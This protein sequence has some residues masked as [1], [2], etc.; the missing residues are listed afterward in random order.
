MNLAPDLTRVL[1][2][3]P[4]PHG[5]FCPGQLLPQLHL[6]PAPDPATGP[7]SAQVKA[8]CEELQ[9]GFLGVGFDPKWA[10]KDIPVMPKV[11]EGAQGLPRDVWELPG[12]AGCGKTD[13]KG[14]PF[15]SKVEVGVGGARAR[16]GNGHGLKRVRRGWSRGSGDGGQS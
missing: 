4:G 11:G 6:E 2:L 10:I 15:M 14:I 16:Y 3:H 13:R 7:L 1:A 12:V 8:I 9:C 5:N